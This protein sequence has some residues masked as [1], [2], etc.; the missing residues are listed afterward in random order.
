[1]EFFLTWLL[2][3]SVQ[4]AA[5]IS[6]GPAFAMTIRNAVS[7]SRRAGILS[8][9][10]LAIGVAFHVILVLCGLAVIVT[11]SI[12]LYTAI[13]YIGALY[14]IYIGVKSLRAR[15]EIVAVDQI[16]KPASKKTISDFK[17]FQLGLLT[18]VLNPKAVV[19]FTAFFTQFVSPDT[20]FSV[21]ILFGFTS[22]AFEFLWFS[23]VTVFLTNPVI[24]ARFQSVRHWIERVC[25]GFLIALG[26]KLAVSKV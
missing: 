22:V 21:L 7:Y 18:N 23:T 5:V 13:K 3:A 20:P 16:E 15:K 14:L 2:L 1:M 6:P 26:I 25:G 11:K 12:I 9:V 17:A 24:N 19:F 8:S 4:A 10:G